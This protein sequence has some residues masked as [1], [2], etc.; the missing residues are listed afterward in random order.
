MARVRLVQIRNFRGVKKLD[1]CP[2]QGFN[3][4]V[5]PGD[6]G[7]STIL[8]AIDLCL[9]ARRNAQ[10]IDADFHGMTVEEPIRI[11]CTIGELDDD[12]KALDSYGLY[13]RGFRA[14]TGVLDDEP[15][16]GAETALTVTLTVSSDLEPRWTLTSDRAAAAGQARNL[17]WDDR[18]RIAPTRVGTFTDYHLG[19]SKGSVLNRLSEE[20]PDASGALLKAAREVRSTFGT[21]ADKQLT[22][23]LKMVR[24][25]AKELGVPVGEKARAML[26]AHSVSL[27]GGSISLHNDAGIPLRSL[28]LGSARLLIAGLQRKAA[29]NATIA[30][31]DELEYGLE[32]HRIHRMLHSLGAKEKV[33]PL[34][35]FMTTHSPVVLRELSGDQLSIVR[36][37]AEH[38]VKLAGASD[39]VQASLRLFPEAFLAR[40]V[41]LCE[42]A[43]EVG[44]MRGLDHCRVAAG[45]PSLGAA[46]VALLD[47]GGISKIYERTP[48]FQKLGYRAGVL[49]DDDKKPDAAKEADFV[50]QGG[51]LLLWRPDYSIEDELFASLPTAAVS[52]LLDRAVQIHGEELVSEH[53]TSVSEGRVTL[54]D[55][56]GAIDTHRALLG[57]AAQ[58]KKAGWF[59]SVSWMES[60]AYDIVGPALPA[61]QQNLQEKVKAL[62]DWALDA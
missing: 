32:P 51:K 12:L 62:F 49:R 24:D 48:P 42:G 17:S 45:Q 16:A 9:G 35:V 47:C 56:R 41:L 6:S 30:L 14:D 19:W 10:F 28:G 23:A 27:A 53:I 8:E 46:G 37:A 7:K 20:R 1:W 54:A 57:R 38:V 33:P 60:A 29:A 25:T 39:A 4:L 26:D 52:G 18:V 15:E 5:G 2:A 36:A 58:T 44:L 59:K 34:Q 31:L 11:D 40:S 61:S 21:E 22:V 43:T 50:A 3:C 13:V 55:C